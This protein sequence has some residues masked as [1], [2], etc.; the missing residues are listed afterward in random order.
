[1]FSLSWL[2]AVTA[3]SP[4]EQ[5]DLVVQPLKMLVAED[6]RI[7]RLLLTSILSQQGYQVLE[8]KNG[9]EA[10]ELC[11]LHRPDIVFMDILMP[12]MDGFDATLKIRSSDLNREI[13]IPIIFLTT[14]TDA[15]ELARCIACGG[16]DVLTKPYHPTLLNARIQALLRISQLYQKIK[17]QKDQILLHQQD[18][19][20]EQ[21]VAEQLFS[22]IVRPSGFDHANLRYFMS[23]V[24]LFNGDVMLGAKNIS[25]SSQLLLG[26]FTGHGLQ[27]AIGTIPVADMFYEMV[28]KGASIGEMVARLNRKLQDILPTGIFCACCIIEIDSL[29]EQLSVWNGGNPD[30]LVCRAD[31]SVKARCRSEHFPLGVVDNTMQGRS[32][33]HVKLDSDDRIYVYSDGVTESSNAT[34][35]MLGQS[36]LETLLLNCGES[37]RSFDCLLEGLNRYRS[38]SQADD[39]SLVE[40]SCQGS[41]AKQLDTLVERRKPAG[42][43]RIVLELGV[44]HLKR[45]NPLPALLALLMDIQGPYRQKERLYMVLSELFTNALDHGVLGLDSSIKDAEQGMADYIMAKNNALESLDSGHIVLDVSHQ[46]INGGCQGQFTIELKDSGQGF[47]FHQIRADL[48]ENVLKHGRGIALLYDLCEQID[49]LGCGNHVRATYVWDLHK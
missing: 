33:A 7:N 25:G 22:R 26:D 15:D 9:L 13:F 20:R 1:L 34:G 5:K 14:T 45:I 16:D 6:D 21:E 39:I 38:G 11:E 24:S 41:F 29:N 23:S 12:E 2:P 17:Q 10:V 18:L 8:A 27:A 40:I 35:E 3:V 31:G 36:R 37:N 44:E 47:D 49:Y 42:P 48:T 32:V 28:A 43:W 30:V 19:Q 4:W 46:V